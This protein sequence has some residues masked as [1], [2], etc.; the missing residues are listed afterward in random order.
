MNAPRPHHRRRNGKIARLPEPT[1]QHINLMLQDGFRYRE[2][3]Q[4]LGPPGTQ[5]L[6]CP[7]SEMNLFN[8]F[9]GGHRDWLRQQEYLEAQRLRPWGRSGA[10]MNRQLSHSPTL[11][12]RQP[13]PPQPSA[14]G[15][16]SKDYAPDAP[17]CY[18]QKSCNFGKI[19]CAAAT[20]FFSFGCG[21][22]ALSPPR[23][24]PGP[25]RRSHAG[26]KELWDV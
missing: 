3:I 10:A 12:S 23:G 11:S 24:G 22:A 19:F 16:A 14:Q 8:R 7:I 21:F 6:P 15:T 1:R 25:L 13:L 5:I 20:W 17:Q 4:A 26:Q 18:T 9:R 2:I